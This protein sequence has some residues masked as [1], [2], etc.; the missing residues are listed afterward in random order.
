M[1]TYFPVPYEDELLYSCVARYA[2]HTGQAHNQ[3]AVVRDVFG[4]GTAVAIPDIPSHLQDLSLNVSRVWKTSV[5]ELIAKFTLA[6]L[7][8]PFLSEKQVSQ[9]ISSMASKEGGKIHARVGLVAS[10]IHPPTYFRFC[11]KCS[12]EQKRTLG[13]CYWLRKHQLPGIDVCIKH[14]CKLEN[15]NIYFHPKQKHHF[16]SAITECQPCTTQTIEVSKDERR[17]IEFHEQLLMDPILRGFGP[18][19]WSLYYHNLAKELGFVHKT[20][21]QHQDIRSC[22]HQKWNN[23]LFNCY[24]D[25]DNNNDWITNL[26]R[27]HRKSFHPIRHLMAISALI[28]ETSLSEILGQVARLPAECIESAKICVPT[29]VPVFQ[30]ELHRNE[31]KKLIADNSSLGVK[32]LRTLSSGGRVYAWLY[33]NDRDW[34]MFNSPKEE[35][36]TMR[37]KAVDYQNWDS[38]NV[39]TL[40]A[41][42]AELVQSQERPRLTQSYLIKQ[43]PRANSIQK[44]L[45]DL[46]QTKQWLDSYA[47][48]LDD[49]IIFRLNTAY[50]FLIEQNIE[51][52]RWR[53]IRIANIREELI[54]NR[55]ENEIQL[56]KNKEK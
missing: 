32:K 22:L 4:V 30:I 24:L 8:F 50:R 33:R 23:S 44:H 51:V 55:I 42:Y 28:P 5:N 15:S 43:L 49:Y 11:P 25:E 20:R 34:L 12:E 35:K 9:T 41:I 17:L 6:P 18:N 16:H 38:K 7:Y 46:P 2:L 54:T 36:S 19:R 31:W 52:K 29:D 37:R 27:K 47:E 14:N 26:F 39:T 48:R 21:V 13:E 53:L 1:L 10:S 45:V 3:K 56:L 40:D